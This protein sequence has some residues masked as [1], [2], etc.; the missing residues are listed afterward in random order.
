MNPSQRIE[1]LRRLLEVDPADSF[2]RYALALEYFGR[3]EVDHGLSLLRETLARDPAYV[4]AYQMLG[5]QLARQGAA[6]EASR[7]LRRGIAVARSAGETHAAAEM[8]D[9]L[10]DL[11]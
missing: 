8:Q 3:D 5:Q 11:E 2:T 9:E 4:P 6:E 1:K 7:V 10:D